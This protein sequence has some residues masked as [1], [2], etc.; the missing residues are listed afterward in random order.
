MLRVLALVLAVS[1]LAGC[2]SAAQLGTDDG[3][4]GMDGTFAPSDGNAAGGVWVDDDGGERWL[5]FVATC[6]GAVTQ[7]GNCLDDDGD[8]RVDSRDRQCLGPCDNG[9]SPALGGGGGSSGNA[10]VSDCYFDFG[11]GQGNDGCRW[12]HRCD[13]LAVEPSFDPEGP[14]CAYDAERVG[15]RECPAEQSAQCIDVCRPL[16]P[17]GCDCFGCCTFDAIA[18]RPAAQGGT[19]VWLGSVAM[20]TNESTCSLDTVEDRTRCRPCTPVADCYNPC[21]PCELCVGRTSLPAGCAGADGGTAMRCEGGEQ[22]CGLRGEPECPLDTYCISG[23]CQP[24]LI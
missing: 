23:C 24:T 18:D 1:P 5:C 20:G 13:P 2:Y 12:D 11:E 7:C 4:V 15:G 19:H 14:G 22:P 10:C 9:E 6:G 17:S 8:G 16:T 21:G 3:G